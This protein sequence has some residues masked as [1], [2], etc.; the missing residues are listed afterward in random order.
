MMVKEVTYA[1]SLEDALCFLVMMCSAFLN[2]LRQSVLNYSIEG[3]VFIRASE[4]GI[5]KI[6]SHERMVLVTRVA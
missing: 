2:Y 5:L 1:P 3:D 6:H 4:K